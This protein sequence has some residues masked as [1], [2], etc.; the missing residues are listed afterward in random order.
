MTSTHQHRHLNPER[1]AERL[2]ALADP[3][4]IRLLQEIWRDDDRSVSQLAAALRIRQGLASYHLQ[5]LRQA[6]IIRLVPCGHMRCPQF[7][8]PHM[9]RFFHSLTKEVDLTV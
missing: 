4:R 2:T 6:K 3:I 7:I 9:K 8:T 1:V 5:Q